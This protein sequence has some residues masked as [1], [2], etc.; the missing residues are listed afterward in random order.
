M[1]TL[2]LYLATIIAAI[3]THL[4]VGAVINNVFSDER[5]WFLIFFWPIFVTAYIGMR[6]STKFLG[7]NI[8]EE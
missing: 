7:W 6:I 4:C 3:L 1:L 5:E 2:V 8:N